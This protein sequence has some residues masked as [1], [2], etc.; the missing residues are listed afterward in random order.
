MIYLTCWRNTSGSLPHVELAL[1]CL[2]DLV[3]RSRTWL[4]LTLTVLLC[5]CAGLPGTEQR[6]VTDVSKPLGP[7]VEQFSISGRL[8][9][10]QGQ[11]R[12]HL[13]FNWEHGAATDT[14]L[15][16]SALG[17]GVAKLTRN[18]QAKSSASLELADGKRYQAENWETLSQ[19]VFDQA[20]PLDALPKWLRGAHAQW[21]GEQ[22]KWQI[23]VTDAKSFES[24]PGR[25]HQ[26]MPRIVQI[27]ADDVELTIV[28]ESRGDEDE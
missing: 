24:T 26:L 17:Q 5:S 28:V 6:I 1:A 8:V 23:V 22:G 21:R 12:D 11:R 15:L 25:Q 14:L 3:R 16:S 10:K 2:W 7:A 18:T 13:R 20:L 9:V 19:Q 27:S 4:L